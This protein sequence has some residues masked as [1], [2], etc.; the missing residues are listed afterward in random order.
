MLVSA[1]PDFQLFNSHDKEGEVLRAQ[2]SVRANLQSYNEAEYRLSSSMTKGEL[3]KLSKIINR[4]QVNSI[5][6]SSSKV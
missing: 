1:E 2:Q 4:P 5:K 3:Q 6:H